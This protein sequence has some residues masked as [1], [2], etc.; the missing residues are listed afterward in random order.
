MLGGIFVNMALL[1]DKVKYD[2]SS[3]T[4]ESKMVVYVFKL[5][6][7]SFSLKEETNLNLQVIK[8]G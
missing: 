1:V 3:K 7:V 4:T 6:F 2:S 5:T 8:A